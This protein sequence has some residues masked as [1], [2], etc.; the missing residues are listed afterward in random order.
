[1]FGSALTHKMSL[2]LETET[3]RGLETETSR[4]LEL[5]VTFPMVL[6]ITTWNKVTHTLFEGRFDIVGGD[7]VVLF[8][9]L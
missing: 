9:L 6:T 4:S 3:N 8:L 1:M 7:V 5:D 2:G